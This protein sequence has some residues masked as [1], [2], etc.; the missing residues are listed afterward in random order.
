MFKIEKGIPVPDSRKR[1]YPL[2]EM[3]IGDSFFVSFESGTILTG[4]MINKLGANIL[5]SSRHLKKEGKF[6]ITRRQKDKTGNII[7]IRCW[8]VK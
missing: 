6:F 2:K 7:G 4:K 8:R 1:K 3:E 5:G